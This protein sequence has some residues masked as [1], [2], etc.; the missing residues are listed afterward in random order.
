MCQWKLIAN[1]RTKTKWFANFRLSCLCR[2]CNDRRFVW[3]HGFSIIC[4]SKIDLLLELVKYIDS[5]NLRGEELLGET[6]PVGESARICQASVSS[7]EN[8]PYEWARNYCPGMKLLLRSIRYVLFSLQFDNFLVRL[9]NF[10]ILIK[11]DKF[12]F[13]VKILSKTFDRTS[14][15]Y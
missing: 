12:S 10:L 3:S 11:T 2:R 9:F 13:V 8:F 1:N 15:C 6:W 5:L 4:S 14:C 7:A